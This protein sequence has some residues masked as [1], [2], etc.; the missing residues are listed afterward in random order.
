M[1][2]KEVEREAN[3]HKELLAK[4]KELIQHSHAIVRELKSVSVN[5]RQS[6]FRHLFRD[7]APMLAKPLPE[8]KEEPN[9]SLL[10]KP[11]ITKEFLLRMRCL[12]EMERPN[13]HLLLINLLKR[14]RDL[15]KHKS[16]LE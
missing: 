8:A 3:S 13:K 6:S 4:F 9:Q 12:Q 15:P 11:K 1:L 10:F 5:L 2:G 16:L 7:F 14:L